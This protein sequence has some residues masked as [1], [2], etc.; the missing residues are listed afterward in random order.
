MRV[1]HALIVLGLVGSVA[2][3]DGPTATPT[4]PNRRAPAQAGAPAK[5]LA[6]QAEAPAKPGARP[7]EAKKPDRPRLPL[8]GCEVGQEGF[9]DL[10]VKV[11]S[12]ADDRFVAV[13]QTVAGTKVVPSAIGIVQGMNGGFKPGQFVGLTQRMK[14]VGT[15]ELVDGRTVCVFEPVD[16][17]QGGAKPATPKGPRAPMTGPAAEGAAVK[18]IQG[19]PA[20]VLQLGPRPQR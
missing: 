8:A 20:P 1:L 18:V 16:A 5:Q 3:A 12:V 2:R 4:A 15:E 6:G 7:A 13:F 9:L 17:A 11:H 10:T 14:C 19:A